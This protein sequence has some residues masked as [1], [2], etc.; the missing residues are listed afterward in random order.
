MGHH[1]EPLSNKLIRIRLSTNEIIA[2]EDLAGSLV[3]V[4]FSH[5]FKGT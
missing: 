3:L 4:F 2:T 1:L 5:T